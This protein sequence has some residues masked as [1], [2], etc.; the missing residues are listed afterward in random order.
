[1]QSHLS[2]LLHA[3][4]ARAKQMLM[5][6]LDHHHSFIVQYKH[7]GGDAGLDMHHDAA[8]VTLNVCLGR[9]FSSG[10]L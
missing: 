4:I 2:P 6:G 7:D 9:D 5:C 10:G 3:H 8:E 1:M